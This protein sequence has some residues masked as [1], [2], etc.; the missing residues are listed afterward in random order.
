MRLPRVL[1]LGAA[2]AALVPTAALARD[3]G[4]FVD[5][6]WS[7]FT[8][9][10]NEGISADPSGSVYF[11]GTSINSSGL[12]RTTAGL[13]QTAA[14]PGV[15]PAQVA[16]GEGYNHVG[17]PSWDAAEGGRVLLP[18]ECYYLGQPDPNTCK[19]GA[20]G[21][22]DPRSL[23]WRYYVKLDPADIP[24]AMWVETS[25]DGSLLWTSAGHDLL[26]Y[27]STDVTPANAAPG[28]PLIKPVRR[29]TGAVPPSGITGAVFYKG[30]LFLAG[31]DGN[32]F[33][34]WSVDTT[35]GARRLEIE[36]AYGGESEG[37]AAFTGLGGK[38][39]WQILPFG[40]GLPTFG[41]GHGALVHFAPAGTVR[42]LLKASPHEIAAGAERRVSFRASFAADG[43]HGPVA[44]ATVEVGGRKARTNGRGVARIELRPDRPGRLRARAT[45]RGWRSG[46]ATLRVTRG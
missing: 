2:L 38:L 17:D 43:G 22:A 3:P 36:R 24:K 14:N 15:I 27:R 26:A 11:D 4:R 8:T 13:M 44:D 20:F 33:Q 29:L 18:L 46:S 9:N 40:R 1:I 25:P 42:I 30:R 7:R 21:V 32:R 28:G 39:H 19:T 41:F 23:A 35:T 5:T 34:V 6:S 45:K 10:Y 16:A 12:F 31:D 37:L